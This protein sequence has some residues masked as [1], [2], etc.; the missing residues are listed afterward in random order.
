MK[1]NKYKHITRCERQDID[2][3]LKKECSINEIANKPRR[4]PS[5]IFEEIENNSANGEY[6]WKK[7]QHKAYV[8]RKYSKYQGMKV[9]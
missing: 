2:Y 4:S 3:Y 1:E 8:R 9:L 5:A 6:R 7:A